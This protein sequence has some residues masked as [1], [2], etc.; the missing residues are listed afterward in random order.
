MAH[1]HLVG[2]VA[3]SL[4]LIR[5]C[6]LQLVKKTE[7]WWKVLEMR[8]CLSKG[9]MIEA[10]QCISGIVSR[11]FKVTDSIQRPTDAVSDSVSVR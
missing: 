5:G 8:P 1:D 3:G 7:G 2:S 10:E 9:K 11:V 4:I 6:K